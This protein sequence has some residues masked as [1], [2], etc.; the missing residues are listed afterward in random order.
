MSDA[1]PATLNELFLGAIERFRTHPVVMRRKIDGIWAEL[2]YAEL[3]E[4]VKSLSHALTT[5]GVQSGDRVAILS[6]NRPE[7]AI[8]DYATLAL[9]AVDVPI[10]PTLP[11]RQ[12]AYILRDSGASVAFV[13]SQ[14]Q[15][16]KLRET[17][18]ECPALRC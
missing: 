5:L 17:Q 7:W 9:G 16:N 13:S 10:F 3:L 1:G 11:A 6:E 18:A 2:S 14:A 8:T 12:V 15:L 4:R